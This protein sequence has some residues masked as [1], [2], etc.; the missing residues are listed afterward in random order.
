MITE[1]HVSMKSKI[2]KGTKSDG[3]LG[4]SFSSE[5]TGF[6]LFCSVSQ[7]IIPGLSTSESSRKK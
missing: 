7:N 6:L 5:M 1:A 2:S 3:C 4:F